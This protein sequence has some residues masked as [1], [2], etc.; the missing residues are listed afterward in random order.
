MFLRLFQDLTKA[1]SPKRKQDEIKLIT[2]LATNSTKQ[3]RKPIAKVYRKL[4][5][6]VAV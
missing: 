5:L 4:N 2:I 6:G 3:H 1:K